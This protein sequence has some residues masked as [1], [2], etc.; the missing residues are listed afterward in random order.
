MIPKKN[1]LSRLN[2]I[3]VKKFGRFLR[4]EQASYMVQ[5]KNHA[6]TKIGVVI[7]KKTLKSAVERNKL[8]RRVY[9]LFRNVLACDSKRHV[10]V[11][12]KKNVFLSKTTTKAFE[13]EIEKLWQR[14]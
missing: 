3:D 10:L 12:P 2:I 5:D 4:S 7:S 11:F 14:N 1:R 8:K 9:T 13:R 6:E